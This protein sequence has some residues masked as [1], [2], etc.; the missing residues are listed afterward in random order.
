MQRIAPIEEAPLKY[1]SVDDPEIGPKQVLIKV[2]A[3]GVCHSNLHMIEGEFR[4]FGSPAKLPIIPGHE[5]VGTIERVGADVAARRVGERVGVQVLH[6]ACGSCEFC[7]TGREHLCVNAKVTGESVD[8]GYAE[9]MAA[10]AD[11]VYPV[12]ENLRDDEAAPLFCPGVTAYRA[13]KR[14]DVRMGNKVVIF[15][16][17]GVGHMSLQF[18]KLA[19]AVVIAV[20]RSQAALR[21]ASELGADAAFSPAELEEHLAK[22]ERPDVVFVHA[23][24]QSAVDQAFKSVKR[25][26]T[27]M[28]AV[29]GNASVVFPMEYTVM[30]SSIGT[31]SDVMETLKIAATGR[32]RVKS[33]RFPLSDATA[34]LARLKKG[35][36]AGRAVLVP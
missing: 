8:G 24:A 12:P 1:T 16:V 2:N 26:G 6:E 23:P 27:I 29:L 7:L 21:L 4:V 20:D 5:V 36:I 31:R 9:L 30:T 35:E 15:G 13:V 18:A 32:V 10:P 19:G 34:V 25:G 17:G 3:C 11:F 33:E 14:A 22:H 28:M